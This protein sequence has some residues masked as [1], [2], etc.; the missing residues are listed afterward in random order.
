MHTR[1]IVCEG[2]RRDD[3][4]WD[5]EARLLDTKAYPTREAERG[6][7]P[8]G[9]PVHDMRVRLT[10]DTAMTVR[11]IEIAMPS[12]P[13]AGCLGAPPA[14]Q[15]LVG[16]RIGPGWRKAI[17][18]RTGGVRGCTHLR[19]LL[20]PMATVAFQTLHGWPEDDGTDAPARVDGDP[21]RVLNGCRAW[22]ARGEMV[23]RLY[24]HLARSAIEAEP[25]AGV[26]SG[27]RDGGEDGA[28]GG[29]SA[30]NG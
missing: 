10:L 15:S 21:G 27:R 12:H 8:P 1:N 3:G 16:C 11:A 29:Q 9:S 24:P 6:R 14:F 2:Y 4:L 7:R 13:Y 19:E 22:D 28:G 30:A 23:A 26:G 25:G 20:M 17:Q 18:E 5:I